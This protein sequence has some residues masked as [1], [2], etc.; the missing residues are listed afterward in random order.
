MDLGG[1]RKCMT[2]M[3]NKKKFDHAEFQDITFGMRK[4]CCSELFVPNCCILSQMI[5]FEGHVCYYIGVGMRVV[6]R[7]MDMYCTNGPTI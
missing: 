4:R 7:Y 2:S 3:H 6:K 5:D 1:C